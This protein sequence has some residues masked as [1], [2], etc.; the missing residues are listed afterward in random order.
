MTKLRNQDIEHFIDQPGN[1]YVA[2][3]FYGEDTGLVKE[4]AKRLACAVVDDPVD[5]FQTAEIS[6]SQLKEEPALLFDE[7]TSISLTGGRR[8][9]LLDRAGNG[10]TGAIELVLDDP[11]ITPFTSFLLVEAA[12]LGPRDSLRKLF[13]N[14]ERGVAIPCY[15]D[16]G[17]SLEKVIQQTLNQHGL[18]IEST[19]LTYLTENLGTDRK[20]TRSELEKLVLFKGRSGGYVTLDDVTSNI[21]DGAPLAREDV[22]FATA[23][24]DQA[25]LDRAILKCQMVGEHPVAILHTVIRHFQRLHLLA[26][27]ASQGNN[28]IRLIKSHRPPVFFKHQPII[29]RQLQQWPPRQLAKAM[30]ILTKAELDC[31]KTGL[32]AEAICGRALIRIANAARKIQYY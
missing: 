31:K 10:Q 7:M 29:E 27:K 5:P 8:L 14:H 2:A 3:L 23:N 9:V 1:V 13:E 20:V 18:K 15:L 16:D 24:G 25:A 19:A 30:G 22:A 32:P 21:G 4:R 11:T 26:V 12:A 28:L 6:V 17:N